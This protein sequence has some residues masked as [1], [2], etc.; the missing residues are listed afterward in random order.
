MRKLV[1]LAL[2]PA[3]DRS[4]RRDPGRSEA[5]RHQRKDRLDAPRVLRRLT[6][7]TQLRLVPEPAPA[8]A[9]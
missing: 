9:S 5:A 7:M 3:A 2:I 8:T 1:V 6:L 4:G